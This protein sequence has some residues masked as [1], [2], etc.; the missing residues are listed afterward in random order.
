MKGAGGAVSQ[1]QPNG[2]EVLARDTHLVVLKVS[3]VGEEEVCKWQLQGGLGGGWEAQVSSMVHTDNSQVSA[4]APTHA[5]SGIPT[6][7]HPAC[8][9]DTATGRPSGPDLEPANWR[10]TSGRHHGDTTQ[11]HHSVIGPMDYKGTTS[12]VWAGSTGNNKHNTYIH[13]GCC[14][15]QHTRLH[16]QIHGDDLLSC[17]TEVRVHMHLCWP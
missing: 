5:P 16:T 2:A 3:T 17:S 13:T 1:E 6:T 4:G 8:T 10:Y 12:S 7:D 11:E 9:P 15:M 14:V